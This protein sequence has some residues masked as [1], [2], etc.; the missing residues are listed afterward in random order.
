MELSEKVLL[1]SHKCTAPTKLSKVTIASQTEKDLSCP[2]VGLRGFKIFGKEQ[3]NGMARSP[4][5][6]LSLSPSNHISLR[7]ASQL[8]RQASQGTTQSTTHY[9]IMVHRLSISEVSSTFI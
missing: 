3:H 6:A 1:E 2:L 5:L 8:A 9:I 4:F 7:R